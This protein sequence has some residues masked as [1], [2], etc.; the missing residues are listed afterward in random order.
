MQTDI[1]NTQLKPV[2]RLI[3]LT[4]GTSQPSASKRGQRYR[5]QTV[6]TMATAANVKPASIAGCE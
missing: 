2:V 1:V 3:H 5:T 6:H 4:Y